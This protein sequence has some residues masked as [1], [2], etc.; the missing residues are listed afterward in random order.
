MGVFTISL[1]IAF[2]S[3]MVFF[4]LHGINNSDTGILSIKLSYPDATLKMLIDHG[5]GRTVIKYKGIK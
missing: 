3:K 4:C 5:D 2:E 1:F